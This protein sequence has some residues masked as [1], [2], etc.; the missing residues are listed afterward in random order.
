MKTATKLT[1]QEHSA[2]L[3]KEWSEIKNSLTADQ[4]SEAEAICKAHGLNFSATGYAFCKETPPGMAGKPGTSLF[5]ICHAKGHGKSQC[6]SKGGGNWVDPSQSQNKG[7]GTGNGNFGKGKGK[8]GKGYGKGRGKFNS[9]DGGFAPP[10]FEWHPQWSPK[11]S[12]TAAP[13]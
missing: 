8:Q 11:W 1:K 9:F 6:S 3:R 5:E 2:K 7:Y 13:A 10:G 12:S 4:I